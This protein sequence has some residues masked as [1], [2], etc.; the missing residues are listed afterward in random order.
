QWAITRDRTHKRR[1][2]GGRREQPAQEAQVRAGRPPA[3]TRIALPGTAKRVHTV[4]VRGGGLKLR[5]LRLDTGNFSWPSRGVARKTRIIDTVYN[6]SNNELVRTK[7]L[8]KNAIVLIDATPFRQWFESHYL[9]PLAR[10]KEKK[11]KAAADAAAAA[12]S[13]AA[14]KA[15]GD[16]AGK[17]AGDAPLSKKTMKKYLE[18][19][20]KAEV[21]QALLEQ[22]AGGRLYACITSRPGQ[23]GR[24]DGYI[25]EG[26]ELD[27]YLRKIRAKKAKTDKQLS[28]LPLVATL[29]AW[30]AAAAADSPGCEFNSTSL[31]SSAKP[32]PHLL[33]LTS[34]ASTDSRHR[35][36]CRRRWAACCPTAARLHRASLRRLPARLWLASRRELPEV[37]RSDPRRAALGR[38]P[39]PRRAGPGRGGPG[40]RLVQPLPPLPGRASTWIASAPTRC[41]W[42]RL[43]GLVCRVQ[44]ILPARPPLRPLLTSRRQP[45]V[46]GDRNSLPRCV[47]QSVRCWRPAAATAERCLNPACNFY[48]ADSV[49][50]FTCGGRQTAHLCQANGTWYPGT[51]SLCATAPPTV[52]QAGSP[53]LMTTLAWVLGPCA[54]L[55]L[56]LLAVALA[57]LALRRARFL[58]R[59][60]ARHNAAAAAIVAAAGGSTASLGPLPPPLTPSAGSRDAAYFDEFD[61]FSY[62]SGGY[63]YD[64][65]GAIDL[66]LDSSSGGRRS[67]P[68][69]RRRPPTTTSVAGGVTASGALAEAIWVRLLSAARP[70]SYD[71]AVAADNPA[72]LSGVG[73]AVRGGRGTA[74]PTASASA[75]AGAAPALQAGNPASRSLSGAQ[76]RR[77]PRPLQSTGPLGGGGLCDGGHSG[78]RFSNY[79]TQQLRKMPARIFT[80]L[81][82][83]AAAAIQGCGAP[84]DHLTEGADGALPRC[85][86]TA[87]NSFHSVGRAF[88]LKF[89]LLERLPP[90]RQGGGDTTY[91]YRRPTSCPRTGLPDPPTLDAMNERRCGLADSTDAL[92]REANRVPPSTSPARHPR[93]VLHRQLP[94]ATGFTAARSPGE[95]APFRES[96]QLPR[97][98]QR[99]LLWPKPFA[100]WA[101]VVARLLREIPAALRP[102]TGGLQFDLA[103]C[104]PSDGVF[105]HEIS[106]TPSAL[107]ANS[108]AAVGLGDAHAPPTCL[109]Q[110]GSRRLRCCRAQGAPSW[111]RKITSTGCFDNS[112]GRPR[113]GDPRPVGQGWP[114]AVPDWSGRALELPVDFD[115]TPAGKDNVYL[116]CSSSSC[117]EFLEFGQRQDGRKS[118]ATRRKSRTF[119]RSRG[120]PY[121]VPDRIDSAFYDYGTGLVPLFSRHLG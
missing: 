96:A 72:A 43:G 5:G 4:R 78:P 33:L 103:E 53:N 77:R 89:W 69:P 38:L 82:T 115:P 13:D 16:A 86:W 50:V 18:R 66:L 56:L 107:A 11:S 75:A 97:E 44:L 37:A 41:C 81:C 111:C 25:L 119:R 109:R 7:T 85:Q 98:L 52:G 121:S 42:A 6:A 104:R 87:F 84:V 1:K 61:Y 116:L 110:G 51:E 55:A 29:L 73:S 120:Y 90:W 36:R 57:L 45:L 17:S 88:L 23:C 76:S 112:A 27:F 79:C 106:G 105:I 48:F 21:P 67:F 99:R 68:R 113:L 3:L 60:R 30:A 2:T 14:G 80:D 35:H 117:G 58:R 34:S 46:A 15:E 47:R 71:E 10:K 39:R 74:A 22:F 49:A 102:P 64:D 101:T 70:P 54:V 9:L 63:Y 114:V 94:S 118:R 24:A 95:L 62:A 59:R 19:Q 20:K 32:P 31:P 83:A 26:K 12:A 91:P 65:F 93:S 108:A 28:Q 8:V 92:A 40:A 100:L